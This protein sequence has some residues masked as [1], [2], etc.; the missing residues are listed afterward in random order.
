MKKVV[1]LHPAHWEQAMG[2][3]E[4]QISYLAKTLKKLDI[5]VHYIFEDKGNII[6]NS[7][8]LHLHPLRK[9]RIRKYFGQRWF[10][11][12]TKIFKHLN[13]IE[14]DVIY[15][16]FYSSWSGFA[17]Q[18][19]KKHNVK[20]IW[21]VAHDNDLM[22][23]LSFK[24][25]L[26]P[27]DAMELFYFNRVFTVRNVIITQNTCQEFNL[28]KNHRRKGVKILQ[29]TPLV[30][31]NKLIKIDSEVTVVWIANLKPIKHPQ[32]FI[33]FIESC[34]DLENIKFIMIGR[35]EKSYSS[36]INAVK[37]TNFKYLGELP[38]EEVNRILC[39]ANILI[40]T[41]DAEGFSNTFV[42]AWMRKVIVLSMNSNPD[43]I[44]TEQRIGFVCPTLDE[45]KIKT[46]LLV[47]NIEIRQQM[48]EKAYKYASDNH[49]LEKNILKVVNLMMI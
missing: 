47:N 4:L 34:S 33:Q 3:A 16:R 10:L 42:Q 13:K 7:D 15:T 27:F 25:I 17:A 5:E 21:A 49:S 40:S 2:G 11:Y 35:H 39:K 23:K 9:I 43:N 24:L 22:Q 29:M 41:S 14:P 6:S 1:I 28:W 38:N 36:L 48:S 44:I 37:N 20:H 45:L 31:E 32:K 18:Y 30:N 19:S 8:A 26:R 46:A 12:R